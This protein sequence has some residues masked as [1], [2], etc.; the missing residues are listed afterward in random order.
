MS[1][2]RVSS[3]AQFNPQINDIPSSSLVQAAAVDVDQLLKR[4]DGAGVT[5]GQVT[6]IH[7]TSRVARLKINT[8]RIIKTEKY[9][10]I[11][12]LKNRDHGC[13]KGSREVE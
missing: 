3:P 9:K 1:I 13:W 6:A 4:A 5:F 11:R 10:E 2:Q 7:L 12:K 8:D